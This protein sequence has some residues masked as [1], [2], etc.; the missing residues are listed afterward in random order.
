M[1]LYRRFVT[2]KSGDQCYDY[3]SIYDG[4]SST[5]PVVE[6][7]LCGEINGEPEYNTTGD[8]VTFEFKSDGSAKDRGFAIFLLAFTQGLLI[9]YETG[10]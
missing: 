9:E 4:L 7:K 5:S 1:F 8:S 2:E 3:L 10:F 6:S